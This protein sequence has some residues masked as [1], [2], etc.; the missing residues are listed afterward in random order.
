MNLQRRHF[1]F[2]ASVLK[3]I[4]LSECLHEA[5]H[6]EIVEQ[7]IDELAYTNSNFNASYFRVA[8]GAQEGTY[9]NKSR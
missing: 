6:K 5:Q 2:I 3:N 1:E 9:R 7:F 4:Q 8:C